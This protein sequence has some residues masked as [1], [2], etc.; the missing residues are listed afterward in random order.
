[1]YVSKRFEQGMKQIYDIEVDE[2]ATN[3]KYCGGEK[4]THECPNKI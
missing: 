2:L 3:W 4:T 1:M